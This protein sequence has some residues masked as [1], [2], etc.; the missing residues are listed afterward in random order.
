[1]GLLPGAAQAQVEGESSDPCSIAPV[2]KTGVVVGRFSSTTEGVGT[3]EFAV[4]LSKASTATVSVDY[5]TMDIPEGDSLLDTPEVYSATAGEDYTAVTGTLTFAPGVTRQ[6][7]AVTILDDAVYEE[8]DKFFRIA[9]SDPVGATIA[10]NR[11]TVDLDI[12]DND[13][14][15]S[16]SLMAVGLASTGSPGATRAS[17]EGRLSV[18]EGDSGSTDVTFTVTQARAVDWQSIAI[19]TLSYEPALGTATAGVDFARV[20]T[21]S[22]RLAAGETRTTFTLSITGDTADEPD[23][24]FRILLTRGSGVVTNSG[25]RVFLLEITI[26]DDDGTPSAP[27]APRLTASASGTLTVRWSAPS[28]DGGSPVTDYDVRYRVKPSSGDP[29]WTEQPDTVDSTALTAT[30]SGLASGTVHQVQVRAQSA[31]GNGAWSASGEG[32]PV[33][34]PSTSP[35]AQYDTSSGRLIV[36]G[37]PIGAA[38]ASDIN[39]LDHVLRIEGPFTSSGSDDLIVTVGGTRV[40]YAGSACS[41]ARCTWDVPLTRSVVAGTATLSTRYPGLKTAGAPALTAIALDIVT[42]GRRSEVLFSGSIPIAL[43]RSVPAAPKGLA[44]A[45]RPDSAILSWE[46]PRDLGIVKYQYRVGTGR[47]WTDLPGSGATTTR[48]DVFDGLIGGA[49]QTLFLRAVNAE[50]PG[51]SASITSTAPAAPIGLVVAA[52]LD[53]AA[54]LSWSDPADPSI[55]D[56]QIRVGAG[57]AWTDLAGSSGASVSGVVSGLVNGSTQT[58]FLRAVNFAGPGSASSVLVVLPILRIAAVAKTGVAVGRFSSANEDIGTVELAV[59]LSAASTATVSV[60]YATMDIPVGDPLLDLT[61]VYSASA[62]VDY[63]TTT[64]TLTFAPGTT[65]E[66]ISV[67]I[68]DDTVYEEPDNF[69]RI[70]LS[71]PVGATLAANQGKVDFNIVD[72]DPVPPIS[73][74]ATGLVSTG[75]PGATRSTP[76]GRLRVVEGDRGATDVTFTLVQARAVGWRS[77]IVASLSHDP[78]LGTATSG[79]DFTQVKTQFFTLAAGE[80]QTTFTVSITGDTAVEADETFYLLVARGGGVVTNS[81][82]RS[83]LIEITIV[84]DDDIP[85]VPRA[86]QLTSSVSGVLTAR[87]SAPADDGGSAITD[88]DVRYRVKPSSGDPAWTEQADDTDSTALT[89]TLSGLANDV[90]HQVQV[91]AQNANGEGAWSSSVEGTPIA[92]PSV[93]IAVVA[94]TG[95]AVGRFPSANEDIG[96]VE[97]AITL[98]KTS[99]ATVSVDYAVADI[100]VGD[101]LLGMAGVY[102]ATAGEDYTAATGTLTFAPGTTRKTVSVPILDDAIYEE[103]DNFFRIALSDPVGATLAASKSKVDFNIVDDDPVPPITLTAT[104]LVSTGS[105]GATASTPEGRLRVVEGD[106]GST[107]VTFT[108]TQSR[109][110]GWRDVIVA[111]LSHDP[112]LGTATSGTDFTQVKTQSFTLS[113]GETQTTF[114]VSITGDTTDEADE[115][116]HLLLTR[117]DGVVTNAGDRSLLIEITIVDDDGIP[118]VPR[119]P[120]LTSSV[121]GVLTVR[122]SAPADDGGSA[123]TDYDVRYRV[124]PVSGGSGGSGDPAWTE[125]ADDTDSTALTTTLSGLTND[126]TYQVQVRAQNA[127]GEGAWSSSVEGTPVALPSVGIAVVAKTGVAVG[128]FSSANEDI[129]TVELAITLSKTSTA[130]VSVDYAVTDIPVGDPLLGMAGVYSAVAG[131][132]YTA[133]TGTLTFAPG[134]T[135]KTVSVPILDDTVYEEP[136]NF[137][138]I[139][140]SDP[141][142]ATLA[143]S[144]SKVDFNIVDDDPVPP[145]TLTATNLVST[146]SPGATA[147]TPEGRLRVVEGD[148][149]ST[150]VAFTLTQSRAVGWR[151]VIVASLSHDPSLGTATSGTDF[152]QVKTQAF[153]LAAGETQTTF[154]VSITGDTANEPDETFHLLLTRGDGVVT[155]SGDRAFL[156]E[157]TIVDDDGKPSAPA[158]PQLETFAGGELTVRWTVPADDGGS[159]VTDYDVRYRVKPVSG[160]SGGS[161]D[162]A[163]TEQAD[164]TDSTDLTTT[165][166]GLTNDATYQVQVRAQN[167]NGE[168]PWSASGEGTPV[169]LPTVG[170]AVVA[171]TGV[172]VGRFSSANEAIG[173]VDFAVTLSKTSARAVSIDYAVTDI[174]VGDPLLGMAGVYS[175]VAGED[176]TAATGTLTFASGTTRKTVSVS[177]LDDAIYE[178]PDNFFRIALS[179]PVGATLAASKSK[180]DF[181]IVD[182]D[183]VPPIT[184]TATDLVSTNSPGATA[185][186]PEGRLRVVEGNSG[187]T[188]VT[189]TLTQSRAVGWRDVIVASLSHDPSLGTATAGTD[190]AQVKTQAFTLAAGETQ[191]TFTVSITGDTADEADETVHLLLTRG[192][193]VVTNSGDRAFLLEITI[194]DDDGRPSAPATPQLETFAGGELTVRWAAPS[195]D[196]GFAVI[197]YDVRYRLKPSSGDPAWTEQADSVDS[198]SLTTTLSGLTNGATYQVQVRAQNANGAGAWSVSGEGTPVTLPTV[199]IAPVAKTGVAI[200][201]FSSANEDIGTVEFAITLSKVGARAVS[202]DYAVTDIPDDDPLLDAQGVYSATAGEDYTAATGTLTFAP[203]TTRKIVSVPILDDAVYEEADSFFRVTLSDPVGA[204]LAAGKSKVDFDIV[205]DDPV[206]PILFS[207]TSLVSTGSPGATSSTPEGR[208]RVVEGDSGST[209]VT[210]TVTQARAVGWRDTIV[211]SLSHVSGSGTATAG[212]DFARV[213]TQGLTIAAGETQTTFTVSIT[214]D[215]ADEPDETFRLLLTRGGGVVV[216]SA[217]RSFLLEITIVDDDGTPS[218]PAAPQLAVSVSGVLTARWSAPADDGGVAITD[219]DV[220]YRVKPVSGSSGDPSWTEQADVTD[221]TALTATLSGL[222]DGTAYQVQVRAQNANGEGAWSA[223][224]EGTPAILPTAGIAVVAK[225]GVAVGR[226][227]SAN[228]AI[229]TVDF[230]VTLSKASTAT[231][232]V[233]YAVTDIPTGDPLLGMANVYS[234]VAGEDYTA[235]TGTVTFAPGTTRKTVSVTILDDTVYE[236]PDNFFR[237]A[238]SDPV[239]AILGANRGKVDF[240][241]VDDDP[242]PPI[243]LTATGLVST[244]SPGATRSTPEGRLRVVEGDSGL[245]DVTFTLAQS[246]AVGWRDLIVASLSHDPSLGTAT[247]GTD[248]TQVKTQSFTLAAGETQTTFTV[249]ITGDTADEADE[250]FHLLL[251][252]GGGVVTNSGDRSLLLEI[253]IV[254][255]DGVPSAPGAPRV[256]ASISGVLTARWSAPADDGGSAITDYDVRY[257]VKPSSGDPAWTE[258]ADGTDSTALAATLSD[259]TDGTAYQ[260]QVRAQNANGVGA[261]S[262]SGEGT[263]AIL[264]T[265]GVAVVAKTGVAVG[266]FSSANEDIGTVELAVTLSKASTATVSVGYAVTDIPAGDPLLDLANVYSAVAGE[267]YTAATG[268]LTFAPGTTRK[269][270]SVPILDDTVYEE[271]DNFFRIALSDPVGAIFAANRGKVDF[272][273]VDDDPFPPITLTATDLVSTGSPGATSSTPEGRLRVVEG[274]SGSTDVT[275]TLTQSRAVGWRDLIVA[276][277]SHDPS[278]GTATSGTDFARVETQ[279]FTLAAGETRTTFTVSITGDTADEADETFHLLLTRGGGV[280]T[281]SGDRSLLLEITIVDDDG[282]PSAPR[283]LRLAASASGELTARWSAPAD[284]GGSEITDYDVR[285]RVKPVSGGSGGSGDPAWTEQADTID[286]TALT[287]ILSG[288]T[289]GTTYQVQVR[290]QNANGDGVWSASV[291]G[292]PAEPILAVFG[293]AGPAAVAEG[294]GK[295][296]YTVTL[297]A[298]PAA[299]VTVKYATSD[300]TATAGSDYTATSGTLTFTTTS[301]STAQTVDVAITDDTVDDDGETFTVAL[302]APGTGSVLSASPSVITTITDDDDPEVTVSFGAASYSVTEGGTISVTVALSVA[303][304]R[305]VTVPLTTT[306]GT[307]AVPGIMVGCR[308]RW[309]LP[310]TRSRR[311]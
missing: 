239:G 79:T 198:T 95:V 194:V 105:P 303:P 258:Q 134:T 192:G 216:N 227:S 284:D 157:I 90:V 139:A 23:E 32:T 244:G 42:G 182:D 251:T 237:I 126:T 1:M 208:L 51:E 115:T 72:D 41:S 220:R 281:N 102:S 117:G 122:W 52:A 85:S 232:S 155:N 252:R 223:S 206:P 168:G 205:D 46:R 236:E 55:I 288:L 286:S 180:V 159:S 213:E 215:T 305:A 29:A 54:R 100:P 33:A 218:A 255:D 86:L 173:T 221:S 8:A 264:P 119:A 69:F 71:D 186:T 273:I 153:T 167:T 302:S 91:R 5:A 272:N 89:A 26:V 12:V 148:S 161:D 99:T 10:S 97:L 120:Q 265:V 143:A 75:S 39:G 2:A 278:L 307:G 178:E 138:R 285:Y 282:T 131:E 231:V 101:P 76:E 279:A 171:K 256:A 287:S 87:W 275:F 295:A 235:A 124:K 73:L 193:G 158:A 204:T 225:T 277:L 297:S 62:G 15:P 83:L 242:V 18:P 249:S 212:T 36:R 259:L 110:V 21:R 80:T 24:T 137:F 121:S 151:D 226:F 294:A 37:V 289:D 11:G 109:A 123:I 254:D 92:L 129:G 34:I 22:L 190:F 276:S 30:L 301:W 45:L 7:F 189:F 141:I 183:P 144:K 174:P 185:S 108:L 228:E 229:G 132:D 266:R 217:D 56:Y 118:S 222:T 195:D 61:G 74:T 107:D 40:V 84:D 98:S 201:R 260:V 81:G 290:A 166:S 57:G 70:A 164:D 125:Q 162:P 253:T 50:G 300:G 296:T 4:T 154:T 13:P 127:N 106:S 280:M 184:L 311:R 262:A 169:A 304:E 293:I 165:L 292:T 181:N 27:R 28:D 248:F 247:S 133:A 112:D 77:V 35:T 199:G 67:P 128:R 140:L 25:D 17:V 14:V 175:A 310:T 240:N 31:N 16:V 113:A 196:G 156:L 179:D 308:R 234:A 19:G 269:T 82:D 207:A 191:T 147:S 43:V 263:P 114:T 6:T 142:G 283:A 177:I 64:G 219:Y 291:E 68:L 145:I 200:G 149:G 20:R 241:I 58:V 230:A 150:D 298:E 146:N 3:V 274:D 246:R 267:D 49:P 38:R 65:R 238:L 103:P 94:K 160:G 130:T 299:D 135:R 245:T 78:D 257:R 59:T 188:D 53:G 210:F 214:G 111:S 309:P 243:T 88:Y 96:T 136:D 63:T 270:V 152:A 233:D 211:A 268:T 176:Y 202:V 306:H 203:G 60:D 66:T 48:F 163:W 47:V 209:D 187:S 170:I 172:A 104:D 197:D 224:G 44:L 93:G 261:W 250:T 116:V 271:P 9:L